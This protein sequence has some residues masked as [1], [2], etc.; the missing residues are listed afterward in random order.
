MVKDQR[1]ERHEKEDIIEVGTVR[2][3][4][5]SSVADTNNAEVNEKR[6]EQRLHNDHKRGRRSYKVQGQ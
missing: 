5:I 4:K 2:M 6:D 1:E 3:V